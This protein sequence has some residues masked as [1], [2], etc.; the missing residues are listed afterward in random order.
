MTQ[1]QSPAVRLP[2]P[3]LLGAVPPVPPYCHRQLSKHPLQ[4]IIRLTQLQL[5]QQQTVSKVARN[6]MMYAIR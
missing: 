2:L 5:S 3:L 6:G 1:H 4:S